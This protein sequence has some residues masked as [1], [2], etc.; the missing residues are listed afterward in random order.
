[1]YV[2]VSVKIKPPQSSRFYPS[3]G[4]NRKLMTIEN[5]KLQENRKTRNQE[6]ALKA[7]RVLK[8]CSLHCKVLQATR[9]NFW[10]LGSWVNPEQHIRGGSEDPETGLRHVEAS[11]EFLPPVE[12]V[13]LAKTL[14]EGTREEDHK[15]YC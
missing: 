14:R 4:E 3:E 10:C 12:I 6:F 11:I 8:T 13:E 15:E 9:V 5:R 7:K 1:M 2:L